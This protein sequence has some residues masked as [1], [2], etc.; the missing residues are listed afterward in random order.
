MQHFGTKS[1]ET[2]RL[3][4]RRFMPDD[5]NDMLKNW[6]ANP[7]IQL[8]YGEP[9]YTTIPEVNQLLTEYLDGYQ[10]SDFYRWAI[11][12]KSSGE[13][14]GQIAFCRVYSDCQ[15]AE[16][17]YCI[18][19]AFWGNGYAGEALNGLINF[20]FRNTDFLKLEA[21]HRSENIKS[22]KVLK[23]SPMHITDK[24]ERFVREK[25]SPEGEVCYCISKDDYVMLYI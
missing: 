12:E 25:T 24:V 15:A 9:V 23:K 5:C 14:I 19:E 22:G 21:Y 3:I 4:C 13:N 11:V 17:E 18:G 8:E 20:T 10:R 2:A 16:I 6:V 1:F 7:N